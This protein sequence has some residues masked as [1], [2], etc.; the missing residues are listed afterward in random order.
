MLKVENLSAG[1]GELRILFEVNASLE[2]EKITAIAGPNGSGK[3][4]LLK[5]VFGLA[6]IHSGRIL[7]RDRDITQLQP[8]DKTRIGI[9]YLPQVD[10]IFINLTVEENLRMAGY[11]LEEGEY[12]KRRNLALEIFPDLKARLKQNAGTLSGGERQFLALASALIRRADLL[13]LDEPSAMLSP[14]FASAIFKK[15]LELKEKFG[16]TILIVEQNIKKAL[17]ISDYA[18]VLI[19]GRVVFQGTPKQLLEHEKFE[20]FCIGA[21]VFD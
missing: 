12:I 2:S 8:H 16:L 11:V 18:Y 9:A 20:R 14:K 7:Y 1:Y 13:M 4:T 19:N 5:A 17:E 6:T 15:I 21:K 3:S 10:N